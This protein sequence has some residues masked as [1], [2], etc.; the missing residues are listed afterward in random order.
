MKYIVTVKATIFEYYEVEAGS[1]EEAMETY[2]SNGS[3]MESGEA[4]YGEAVDAS[5]M[6]EKEAA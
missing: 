6:D 1:P 3:F 2:A 4:L 5:P